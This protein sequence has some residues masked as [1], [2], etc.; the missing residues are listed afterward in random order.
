MKYCS[1]ALAVA[2]LAIS[3]S[4]S[5]QKTRPFNESLAAKKPIWISMIE[6]TTAN[7]FT[8][9]KAFDT[10]FKHH[11]LPEDEHDVIGEHAEREKHLSRRKQRKLVKEDD[12]RM[13]VRRYYRWHE[14][15][16]PYVQPDGRIL[17]PSQRLAIWRAQQ[18]SLK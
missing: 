3:L 18:Q 2:C 6:D 13:D 14:Q 7:F 11:E 12:M 8:V 10:Y 16:L 9:E 5:A 4:A 1:I 15:M 17:T